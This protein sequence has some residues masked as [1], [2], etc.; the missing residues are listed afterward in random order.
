MNV[1]TTNKINL[2]GSS[3]SQLVSKNDPTLSDE[4]L[5]YCSQCNYDEF[6]YKSDEI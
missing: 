2:N 4:Q 1:V 5:V 3:F 6:L